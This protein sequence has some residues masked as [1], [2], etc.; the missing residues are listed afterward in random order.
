ML[1]VN[2]S[3]F[4][5]IY[6]KSIFSSYFITLRK[7]IDLLIFVQAFI[8][9][10]FASAAGPKQIPFVRFGITEFVCFAS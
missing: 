9:V 5:D 10:R 8:E 1:S 6:A 3:L 4:C 7:V 2:V